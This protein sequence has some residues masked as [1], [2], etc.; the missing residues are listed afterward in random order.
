MKQDV[1]KQC[2]NCI[3]I[4]HLNRFYSTFE[5]LKTIEEHLIIFV[6]MYSHI[7]TFTHSLTHLS[8]K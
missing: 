8:I 2:N 4:V 6:L 5:R 1:F 3:Y 7:H